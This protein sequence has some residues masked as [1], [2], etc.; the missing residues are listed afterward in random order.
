MANSLY[1]LSLRDHRLQSTTGHCVQIKAQKPT[2]IPEAL[3]YEAYAIGCVECDSQGRI[4]RRDG[5]E[6]DAP[7][8][9]K[10]GPTLKEVLTQIY[11]DGE[12]E[13]LDTYG[14]PKVAYVND[15]LGDDQPKANKEKI[16]RVWTLVQ[17]EQQLVEP[18]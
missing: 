9:P 16:I 6:P 14:M 8:A 3:R 11:I 10:T 4:G 1:V 12:V 13:N 5:D 18:D 2:R 17:Q 15:L 7:P